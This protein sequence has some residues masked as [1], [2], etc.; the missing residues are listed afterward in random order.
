MSRHIARDEL[1]AKIAR[2]DDFVLIEV[3]PPRTPTG[4]SREP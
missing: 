3:R 4:I 2:G 1:W